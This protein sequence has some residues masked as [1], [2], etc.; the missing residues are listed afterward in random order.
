MGFGFGFGFGFG[1]VLG[2]CR[3]LALVDQLLFNARV[4]SF[5]EVTQDGLV[6]HLVG[7][8]G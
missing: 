8:K 1:L 7:V 2:L 6:G 4:D 3:L 5:L